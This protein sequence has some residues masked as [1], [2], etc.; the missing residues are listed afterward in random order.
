MTTNTTSLATTTQAE[1]L[2][3]FA[4]DFI[5]GEVQDINGK[6][7]ELAP[8]SRFKYG[9]GD[10]T[11]L[12][13]RMLA[14]QLIATFG[15][16]VRVSYLA[17]SPYKHVPSAA[18]HLL[19]ATVVAL[20][21]MGYAPKGIFKIDRGV[22]KA[23]DYG[24]LD[25]TQ[26]AASNQGRNISLSEANRAEIDN[27]LVIVLDDIR[28]SGQT[29]LETVRALDKAGIS[30]VHYAYIAVV[31]GETGATQTHIENHLTH[32]SM[33]SLDELTPI[34]LTE[35]FRL[36]AR[37]CK[38]ILRAPHQEIIDLVAVLPAERLTA[39]LASMI[40]D[41]YHQMDEHA[42]TFKTFSDALAQRS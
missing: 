34:A 12:Y 9:D 33:T 41:G 37:T 13:G 25:A 11:T 19:A 2:G 7:F 3:I 29:E 32:A 21:N 6:P 30:R 1:P 26:R 36:N 15:D 35:G 18:A 16:D 42:E 22:V 8:Y 10:V 23:V 20:S 38:F 27:H 5:D 28:V 17:S 39:I 31:A 24:M 4:L 14:K 40:S